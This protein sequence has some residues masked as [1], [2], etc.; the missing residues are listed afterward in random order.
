MGVYPC[1]RAPV[2][3]RTSG[4]GHAEL[5]RRNSRDRRRVS[6][7]PAGVARLANGSRGSATQQLTTR[8]SAFQAATAIDPTCAAGQAGLALVS[9]AQAVVRDVPFVEAIGEAKAA[10]LRALALDDQSADAQV[11]LGQVMFFGEWDWIAAERS[12]QRG[13]AINPNH[14]E[15]YLH[16]G[17]LVEGLGDLE[18]GFHLKLQG[19]ERDSTSALAT[20]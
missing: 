8:V 11:A 9:V 13:L 12:F 4:P 10:A 16:Y 18:R 5:G 20:C 19:L 1:G 17:G 2:W 3:H 6:W 15:A 14:A 7:L